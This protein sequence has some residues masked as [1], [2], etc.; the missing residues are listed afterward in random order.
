M[1]GQD[2]GK[3]DGS[4]GGRIGR[5]KA[6]AEAS[7]SENRVEEENVLIRMGNCS[8]SILPRLGGKIASIRVNE[9]EL[10]QAPLAAYGPRTRTM[11]FDAGDASGCLRLPIARWKPQRARPRFP[12]MGIC[13]GGRGRRSGNRGQRARVA[14]PQRFAGSVSRFRSGLSGG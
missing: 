10:L 5:V 13:G 8:V 7:G 12:I 4:L 14:R 9:R 2:L 1:A 6:M 11:A 3:I